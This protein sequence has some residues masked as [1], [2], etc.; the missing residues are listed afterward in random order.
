MAHLEVLVAS[1]IVTKQGSAMLMEHSDLPCTSLAEER[2]AQ[3]CI[4]LS[5]L[6]ENHVLSA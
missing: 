2:L 5:L 4:R 1:S 3:H 6:P